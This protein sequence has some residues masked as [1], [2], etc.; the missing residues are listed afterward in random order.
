MKK[1]IKNNLL[2]FILGAIIFSGIG[3]YAEYIITADK[4]EYSKDISVK[5]KVD[6]LYTKVKPS[7]TGATSIT[8]STTTQTLQTNNKLLNSN[9]TINPIPS[10][11]KSLTTTTTA[12]ASDLLAGKTAYDNNGNLITGNI[13]TNCVSGTFT[14]STCTTSNGQLI[15][16]II[17]PTQ[18]TI[19]NNSY[20]NLQYIFYYNKNISSNVLFSTSDSNSY[21]H[22]SS[23]FEAKFKV[24][25]N[26]LY[27]YNF[28]AEGTTWY[29]TICK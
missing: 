27:I 29:Y 8:P 23:T 11:Y 10:T 2:G 26:K 5:D 15:A 9:I 24:L 22:V 18:I 20:K 19:F 17:N 3:A 6:D 12:T 13:S 21:L 16:S 25:N 14:C 4:V 1:F 28:A 7:Y